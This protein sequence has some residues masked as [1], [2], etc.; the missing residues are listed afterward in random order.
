M[1]R[2]K[3]AVQLF[4]HLR[5]FEQCA[6]KLYQHLLKNYDIDV[7]MHTWDKIDHNTATWHKYKIKNMDISSEILQQKVLSMY[8]LK[9]MQMETQVVED[10]GFYDSCSFKMSIFGVQSALYSMR[11]VNQLRK[12]YQERQGIEYD[13]VLMIRPDILLKEPFDFDAF[14]KKLTKEDINTGLFTSGRDITLIRNDLRFVVGLDVLFFS[15]ATVM[16]AIIESNSNIVE[17]IQKN[18]KLPQF[19]V[20]YLFAKHVV[21]SG[22]SCYFIDYRLDKHCQILRGGTNKL[23]KRFFTIHVR[24]KYTELFFFPCISRV[25]RIQLRF[26]YF[27]YID[28]RIGCF[29]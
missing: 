12:S 16:D 26:G 8:D 24:K 15:R 9:D 7:F 13:F 14:F 23:S 29:D 27:Y 5:T 1:K 3:I 22:F 21:D 10:L 6:P 19:G 28:I 4:G 18:P 17:T 25:F 11:Q 2:F 20:D